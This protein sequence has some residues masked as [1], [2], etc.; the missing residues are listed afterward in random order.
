MICKH[1][2]PI[3]IGFG[4]CKDDNKD[5]KLNLTGSFFETYLNSHIFFL[6]LFLNYDMKSTWFI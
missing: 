1:H 4:S 3:R 2:V 6:L 5:K